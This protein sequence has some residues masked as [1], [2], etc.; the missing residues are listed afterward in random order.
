[1][2]KFD[3]KYKT[4]INTL[5]GI[6]N[7]YSLTSEEEEALRESIFALQKINEDV[8]IPEEFD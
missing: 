1:M 6:A 4:Q 8:Y 3:S 5:Y 2:S 7:K